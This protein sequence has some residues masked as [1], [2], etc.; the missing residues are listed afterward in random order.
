M[1][2][3]F[4][5]KERQRERERE[6]ICI[7][8]YVCL[9]TYAYIHTCVYIYICYMCISMETEGQLSV[10]RNSVSGSL[11]VWGADEAFEASPSKSP[12]SPGPAARPRHEDNLRIRTLGIQWPLG[13]M[14]HIPYWDD[15]RIWYM[16]SISRVIYS[17]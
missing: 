10:L 5:F 2:M 7:N 15:R 4:Y 12:M 16:A 14:A 17:P 1:H 8:V 11:V 6:R 3:G 9:H 13:F